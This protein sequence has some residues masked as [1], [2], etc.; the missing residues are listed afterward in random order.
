MVIANI[1]T[2]PRLPKK[3]D[4]IVLADV[5]EHLRQQREVLARV[6]ESL[7]PQGILFIS[8]PN[9]ANVTIRLGLLFGI[10]R[11]RERGI[12][13]ETHVRFYTADTIRE[14]L[15]H[16]GFEIMSL[17]GSSVPIRLIVDGK[18]PEVAIRTGERLLTFAT[19]WWKSLLAY[20]IIIVARVANRKA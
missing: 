11:Y 19:R 14:E 3:I 20:Q 18:V 7:S 12:L 15:E 2:V 8:V 4:V 9:I 1:E 17:H 5:L 13:D 16:A 6:R 10:F